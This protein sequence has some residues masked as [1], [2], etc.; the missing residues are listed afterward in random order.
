MM[1]DICHSDAYRGILARLSELEAAKRILDYDLQTERLKQQENEKL[2]AALEQDVMELESEIWESQKRL[3]QRNEQVKYHEEARISIEKSIEHEMSAHSALKQELDETMTEKKRRSEEADR[4]TFRRVCQVKEL[5][6]RLGVESGDRMA[7]TTDAEARTGVDREITLAHAHV[8]FENLSAMKEDS[9][10]KLLGAKNDALL[11]TGYACFRQ[12]KD[13]V[14]MRAELL[15]EAATTMRRKFECGSM[16]GTS[17]ADA[18]DFELRLVDTVLQMSLPD[19]LNE[20]DETAAKV[21]ILKQL[22][23][24]DIEWLYESPARL[25]GQAYLQKMLEEERMENAESV[26]NAKNSD[27]VAA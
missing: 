21:S 15:D 5:L 2:C 3:R 1:A 13:S 11:R 6:G 8:D 4:E 23:G 9:L 14:D 16:L 27:R 20:F 26:P 12:A 10:V 19:C 25:L 17:T 22:I 7:A 24:G 18:V